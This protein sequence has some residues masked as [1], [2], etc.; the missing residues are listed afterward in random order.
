MGG[1]CEIIDHAISEQQ[2]IALY[3]GEVCLSP[4]QGVVIRELVFILHTYHF[5][6]LR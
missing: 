3:C 1:G 2:R 6:V 5:L 4:H